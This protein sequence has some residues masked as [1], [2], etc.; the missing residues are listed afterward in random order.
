MIKVFNVLYLMDVQKLV[1][2]NWSIDRYL[3]GGLVWWC[4]GYMLVYQDEFQSWYG[5]IFFVLVDWVYGWWVVID[6]VFEQGIMN[7][8]VVSKEVKIVDGWRGGSW[9]Q[10]V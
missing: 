7:V 4:L 2:Y 8:Q 5:D 9:L 10:V 1:V 6:G 3:C